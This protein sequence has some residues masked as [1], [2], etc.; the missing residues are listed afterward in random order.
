MSLKK[1]IAITFIMLAN[2]MIFAH[3]IVPHDH[4]VSYD[5]CNKIALSCNHVHRTFC[6]QA[7]SHKDDHH[8]C[9]SNIVFNS[10]ENKNVTIDIFVIS[11]GFT[12][13]SKVLVESGTINTYFPPY[14]VDDYVIFISKD[15][16]LRAPPSLS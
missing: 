16:P 3:A 14:I 12:N 4:H 9:F 10:D 7:D 11:L 6:D 13:N 8:C 15:S 5:K 1:K 2:I